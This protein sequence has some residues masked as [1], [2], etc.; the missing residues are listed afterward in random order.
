MDVSTLAKLVG[1]LLIAIQMLSDYPTPREPP[2]VQFVAHASLEQQACDRPC[3]VYGWF[4]PGKAIYLDDR[5]DPLEDL[6]AKSILLHELV[7]YV[8]QESGAFRNESRCRAWIER[9]RE[10]LL[11]QYRWLASQSAP[12]DTYWRLGSHHNLIACKD[13]G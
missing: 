13:E 4:P 11:I 10:A 3:E 2:V 1:E 9:E 8:Q 12:A 6:V 7:H 5:L